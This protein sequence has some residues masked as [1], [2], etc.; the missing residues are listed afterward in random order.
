[1]PKRESRAKN[2]ENAGPVLSR[3]QK[4]AVERWHRRDIQG[5]PYNPRIIDAHAKK[6]LERN[7][8]KVGLLETLVVNRTTKNLV[9]GHQRLTCLDALEGNGEYF[10]DVAVVELSEKQEKEQ[11]LFMNNPGAQGTWDSAL[12]A[13]L[14]REDLAI[15]ATGFEKTDLEVIFDESTFAKLFDHENA[16]PAVQRAVAEVTQVIEARDAERERGRVAERRSAPETPV[17]APPEGHGGGVVSEKASEAVAE[18]ARA[19]TPEELRRDPSLAGIKFRRQDF[20][21]KFD[22]ELDTEFYLVIVCNS[23]E[24]T[25]RLLRAIGIAEDERYVDGRMLGKLL[26]TDITQSGG[27]AQ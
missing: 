12:L 15:E 19:M 2:F 13:D 18:P 22:E 26:G 3:F 27:E 4:F 20:T 1:M 5:A 24:E 23:R 16:P 10:L 8:K 14:L 21:K 25:S 6:K 17:A 9:S 11:N 7:L